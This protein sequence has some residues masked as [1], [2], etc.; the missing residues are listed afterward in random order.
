[1]ASSLSEPIKSQVR[2]RA[3]GL[4]EYCHAIEKW[5]FVQF[6]IDH[7]LP[8]FQGGTVELDN[9]ALACFHCNRKK[10]TN[11]SAFDPDTG[12]ETALFNPRCDQWQ[13]H[14]IWSNNKLQLVGISSIGRTTVNALDC[15]RD[16]LVSIRSADI[17]IDRHPP[18]NDPVQS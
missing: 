4:C 15:N 16:R 5:Q 8:I 13:D 17:V 7:I 18:I 6:T 12:I 1:M 10:Y 11:I 2:E 3:N 14:F 9:L